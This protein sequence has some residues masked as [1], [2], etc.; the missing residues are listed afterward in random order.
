[1]YYVR[2]LL[3]TLFL[4]AVVPSSNESSNSHS[5]TSHK[6]PLQS[7]RIPLRTQGHTTTTNNNVPS[8]PLLA[9]SGLS[10]SNSSSS[11]G[12]RWLPG[13]ISSV[14]SSMTMMTTLN[15][16][17]RFLKSKLSSLLLHVLSPVYPL[18]DRISFAEWISSSL[19]FASFDQV[20]NQKQLQLLSLF[21]EEIVFNCDVDQ[22][23]ILKRVFS[24]R[25]FSSSPQTDLTADALVSP[26]SHRRHHLSMLSR[27]KSAASVPNKEFRLTR[28]GS[29]SDLTVPGT[30]T[31]HLY[32]VRE[33]QDNHPKDSST[34]LFLLRQ[35]VKS[36][37]ASLT[38]LNETTVTGVRTRVA[39]IT[40]SHEKM[41]E[42]VVETAMAVTQ[43]FVSIQNIE[44]RQYFLRTEDAATHVYL[45]KK[46][47]KILVS[48]VTHE[49]HY[50][51][52]KE[53]FPQSW[54]LDPSEGPSR[55]RRKLSRCH[56][57]IPPKFFQNGFK[58]KSRQTVITLPLSYIF[59][60]TDDKT[61]A[62]ILI[63]S[64]H[65]HEQILL[66]FNSTL[67]TPQ[68]EYSGELLLSDSRAHFVGRQSHLFS[69]QYPTAN[70]DGS[71]V[72]QETWILSQIKEF[73]ERRYQL[74]ERALEIFLDNGNSYLLD[75]QSTNERKKVMHFFSERGIS[76]GSEVKSLTSVTKLWRERSITNFDY[77]MF[78]NKLAGRSFND[79]MIYP[80]YPF[81]LSDYESDELDLTNASCFR[82]F[83]K[84]MAIQKTKRE[85]YYRDQ[86]NYLKSEYD[87][88]KASEDATLDP[89][90]CP[91]YHYG[92]HYS[93]SGTV[94]HFL[95][96]LPPF[97]QMFL[98]YQDKSFDIPDRTF[99]SMNVTWSLASGDSTTDFK[100]LIPE[101]F[102]LPEMLC[103]QEHFEFG[104]RHN[105]IAVHDVIL[106]PWSRKDPRLFVLI[107]RQ[108]L[109][110]D[111]VTR[112]LKDWI[113]L[114]FGYKQSG[115]EA[116]ESINVFHPATYFGLQVNSI[117]D[118]V[119]RNAL[120]TMIK[121]FGQMPGQ[122]FKIPHPQCHLNALTN[123]SS[124]PTV[125]PSTTSTGS[126]SSLSSRDSISSR[127]PSRKR[128]STLTHQ[129]ALTTVVVMGE[130]SG[131]KW[132]SYVGSPS[133]PHPVVV[134]KTAN[135]SFRG[136]MVPLH[137]N[138]I[139]GL[140]RNS[141]LL[142]AFNSSFKHR[143]A[144]G[145]NA[146]YISD[147]A[148]LSWNQPDGGIR[149]R[150]RR[151][152]VSRPFLI[153]PSS[154][155]DGISMC[156]SLSSYELLF[157]A[158]DSGSIAVYS[159]SPPYNRAA[160]RHPILLTWLFAHKTRV[161]A[162]NLSREFRVAV[163]CDASG[164]CVLWDLNSLTYVRS[165][166]DHEGSPVTLVCMSPTLG[167]VASV[168]RP[169]SRSYPE[170]GSRLIVKTINGRHVADVDDDRIITAICYSSS[171]EG[172]SVNV[173]VTAFS[174]GVIQLWSSWDLCPVR[175]IHDE[176]FTKEITSVCFFCEGSYLCAL[177]DQGSLRVW[178]KQGT[179][180]TG[181]NPVTIL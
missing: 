41:G 111:H 52:D 37:M 5:S 44:R 94:L 97:T 10:R 129:T 121:T 16:F 109:E 31:N 127:R 76:L 2:S 66:T 113:D 160:V 179:N 120:M 20:M 60:S 3:H 6:S 59:D 117:E 21:A 57:N 158:F 7:S 56:L 102:Y 34:S 148:V 93:N 126:M 159:V 77:L 74:Q 147:L 167:D 161:T 107:N 134:F 4:N 118:S 19:P 28:P 83:S 61:E 36:W 144:N 95:V 136:A 165:L 170:R 8:P 146:A 35:E 90:S 65:S 39:P 154:Q 88:R 98:Q 25:T 89:V 175:I 112:N 68:V 142:V 69:T 137:T 125:I 132:G 32:A 49:R 162:M 157:V 110:S 91:V 153:T 106:P 26:T 96:R 80:V 14:A 171:P 181:T 150:D 103:N 108:A 174:D 17:K 155:K 75:F 12:R 173:L 78:L 180:F 92:S 15:S 38:K 176:G 70:R 143:G 47:W 156:S 152:G 29:G 63:D 45:T 141:C 33:Q 130:V 85:K 169:S 71:T 115:K 145:L 73:L 53:S 172:V 100:E 86:Y 135:S 51:Y 178:G 163:S 13:V 164:V 139:F 124:K 40:S 114:I 140:P 149:V 22:R 84:P 58:E 166:C 81:V 116:V 11:L 46:K 104:E 42:K 177:N 151:G 23:D 99:H 64:I 87:R 62:S 133:E 24:F 9:T 27:S 128:N 122:L 48:S 18:Q 50:F 55:M 168:S 105:G 43:A 119:K 30:E 79:L 82:N 1:M 123:H 101:F 131:L 138:D 67:I 54:Q 72:T